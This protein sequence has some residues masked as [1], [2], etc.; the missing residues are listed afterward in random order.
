MA[1]RKGKVEQGATRAANARR[2]S[3]VDGAMP[4]NILGSF[5]ASRTR[6]KQAVTMTRIHVGID[7][8]IDGSSRFFSQ[9]TAKKQ[10]QK[11]FRRFKFLPNSTF[12]HAAP[13][14]RRRDQYN[15][16]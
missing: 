14:N 11:V 12:S 6:S 4:S 8:K 5:A 3:E 2:D 9:R 10:P 15:L 1:L 13:P 16:M 7:T